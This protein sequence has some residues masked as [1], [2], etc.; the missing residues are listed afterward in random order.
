MSSLLEQLHDIEGLDPISWWPLAIGW[1]IIIGFGILFTTT[2][3]YF[4]VRKLAFV[5]S[6]KNDTFKK[7][8]QLERN[9]SDA[10][11]RETVMTLSE[12]L[13]RIA[14]KR[15]PRKECAGLTGEAWLNWLT[16]HDPENFDWRNKG[17]L[18]IEVPYAPANRKV[19]PDQ[20]IDLLQAVKT[21]VR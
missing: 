13:R 2:L 17:V 10:T 1:W 5:R 6:W 3:T 15:F 9:L 21:W 18:L 19:S 20:I 7:L 8:A 4:V 11:A 12:Y 14:V 16:S